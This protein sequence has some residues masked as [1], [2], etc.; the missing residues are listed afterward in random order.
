[1]NTQLLKIKDE[2]FLEGPTDGQFEFKMLKC[3]L[4]YCDFMITDCILKLYLSL[5]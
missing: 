4:G 3:V 2:N 5:I 1:M